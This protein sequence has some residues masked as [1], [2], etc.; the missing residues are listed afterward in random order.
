MDGD[1]FAHRAYHGLPKSIRR[2]G[3]LG[4]GAILGFANYLTGLYQSERPRAVLVGWDTLDVPTWRHK[5]F[6][7]YQGGREFDAELLEQLEALPLFV[8]ACGFAN[9]KA[10]GYEADDFL[11]AAV[12]AEER[13][14]GTAIV[15]SGDRDAFQL[16]SSSTTI[17]FPIR[18]GVMARIGPAEVRDRYGVDPRQVP[19]FIALRG[20]PSD[21][22][23]GAS[24][25]GPKRAEILLHRYGSLE[26][27]LATGSLANQ[28]ERLRLY[29]RIATMDADAP[30]PPLSDQTP[31]WQAA[32]S[33]ARTWELNELAER[34]EGF[35]QV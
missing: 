34:L 11:A 30:I 16:A 2:S 13:R 20:D 28:A 14:G 29:R 23:P 27:L 5:L 18:A 9:A 6:E 32:A 21:K 8:A 19:D 33:L 31:T 15:A 12:A 7:T 4:G 25:V 10:A 24:G 26:D 1:S 17:V 22:I 35:E 3:D